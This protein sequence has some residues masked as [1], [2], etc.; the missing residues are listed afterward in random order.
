VRDD[1]ILAAIYVSLPIILLQPYFGLLVY[2]WL[3]YMRPQGMAWGV[4]REAPLSAWV[5]MA[6]LAGIVFAM[7]REKLFTLKTQTVLLVL[8]GGWISLTTWHAVSPDEAAVV[9]GYYWKAILISVIT[10]GLVRDRQRLR[11]LL[12]LIALS[13]GFLGAKS[14]VFGLVRGGT[15]FDEGPGGMMSDNN[16]YALGLNMVVP[17][18]VGIVIAERSK[19]LRW[20]AAVMTFLS[21]LTILFTFSRGGLLTLGAVGAL[22]IWRSKQRVVASG[23]LLLGIVGF[24]AFS[25]QQLKEDYVARAGTISSYEEDNSAMGRIRA[26]QISWR[27]FRDHPLLGVGPNNLLTVSPSYADPS[28]DPQQEQHY[29]VAHNSYF[30][31]LAECGWPSVAL[32]LLVLGVTLARLNRLRRFPA[33]PWVETYAQMMQISIVAYMTGSVFLNMAYFDLIYHLVGISVS[34]E[35]AAAAYAAQ[36]AQATAEGGETAV[37]ADEP[38]WRRAPQRVGAAAKAG[39]IGMAR[40][41]GL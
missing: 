2:S 27:V 41:K 39:A 4:S 28:S 38:W 18:L 31:L 36:A 20:T 13:I 10:T 33:A 7:G 40:V 3:G 14:G 8:L 24:L 37:L 22:L 6:M 29:H 25:S 16:T 9:Y 17:L 32:F 1:L 21:V 23:V 30:E 34:L 15:R 35:V 5:A 12:L 26:W 11:I 19:I